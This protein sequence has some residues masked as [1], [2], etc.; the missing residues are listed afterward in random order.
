MWANA[1]SALWGLLLAAALVLSACGNESEVAVLEVEPGQG[2]E[3]RG[4][5]GDGLGTAG[6]AKP[7]SPVY[8]VTASQ[9]LRRP[10]TL[11]FSSPLAEGWEPDLLRV[12]H[13]ESSGE[14]W[15]WVRGEME[16]GAYAVPAAR[17]SEWQLQE[18]DCADGVDGPG[19]FDVEVGSSRPDD[20]LLYACAHEVDG[21]PGVTIF[22]NR[23]IG[24][25]FPVLDGVRV[26]ETGNRTIAE[27]A[28]GSVNSFQY[29]SPWLLVPGDGYVTL[30]FDSVPEEIVFDATNS[31]FVFDLLLSVAPNPGTAYAQCAH[32]VAEAA[33]TA[34]L[35][36]KASLKK[37]LLDGVIACS[38]G[39]LA[40][41]IGLPDMLGKAWAAVGSLSDEATVSFSEKLPAQLPKPRPALRL[42]GPVD[43]DGIEP[44]KVGMTRSDVD[45]ATG[46]HFVPTF[47][48]ETCA[49]FIPSPGMGE[50]SE[51]DYLPGVSLMFVSQLGEDLLL[52]GTVARVDVFERGY[53]TVAGVGV[54]S[55][56]AQVKSLYRPFVQVTPHFYDPGGHYLVVRS[57]DP[58]LSPYRIVF[59]TDGSRVTAFRAGRLPEVEFVEHCF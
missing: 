42:P 39:T 2:I 28:W 51:D 53:K 3:V 25:E 7:L 38:K 55:T 13:R 8:R 22:N 15:G 18:I 57:P 12:A 6:I 50:A 34:D 17:L 43:F 24:L 37:L 45:A 44:V 58:V 20:P 31:A 41:V 35:S 27:H 52:D 47:T 4:A 46:L 30:A 1:S 14:P 36:R 59:E 21:K 5:P 26:V 33:R 49:E 19:G 40:A 56:E 16:D 29:G 11:E 23:P 9:A 32:N 54:G 10:V 48:Q